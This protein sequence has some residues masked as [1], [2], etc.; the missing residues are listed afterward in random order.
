MPVGM[1]V[2]L[3]ESLGQRGSAVVSPVTLD[4]VVEWVTGL[5]GLDAECEEDGTKKSDPYSRK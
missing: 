3:L 4:P 1:P 5:A 2:K